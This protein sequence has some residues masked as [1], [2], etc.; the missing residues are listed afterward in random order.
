V[1]NLPAPV[2]SFVGREAEGVRRA[3][4]SYEDAWPEVPRISSTVSF[5]PDKI[6]VKLDGVRLR[7]ER[8]QSVS[9]IPHGVD[10]TLTLD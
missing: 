9:V 5:E 6:E 4:W 8:G 3:A 7:L 10:R 2:P 1:G